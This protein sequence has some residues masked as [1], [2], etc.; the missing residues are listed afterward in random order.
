MIFILL[1]VLYFICLRVI[2]AAAEIENERERERGNNKPHCFREIR[3]RERVVCFKKGSLKKLKCVVLV[4]VIVCQNQLK[5][6]L[7][8]AVRLCSMSCAIFI[9]PINKQS[10]RLKLLKERRNE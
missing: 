1:F 8:A 10:W 9:S 4:V 5:S 3:E 6:S 7:A 2:A